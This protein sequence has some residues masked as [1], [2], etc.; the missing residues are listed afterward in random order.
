[1]ALFGSADNLPFITPN[2]DKRYLDLMTSGYHF[3]PEPL[4]LAAIYILDDRCDDHS[5]PFIKPVSAADSLMLLIAN[6]STNYL[7][8]TKMRA[9]EFETLTQVVEAVPLRRVI[10]HSNP[11]RLSRLSD[12][13]LADLQTL[14]SSSACRG[15]ESC[16]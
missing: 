12:V 9:N 15:D 4:S 10:P 6:S 3:Q 13:I 8:D 1:L 16:V 7:L 14:S 11:T 5:A 2:W